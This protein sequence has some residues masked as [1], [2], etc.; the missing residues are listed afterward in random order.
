M[1][2]LLIT[3]F[4]AA[5]ALLAPIYIP[6]LLGSGWDNVVPVVSILC[7]SAL[8]ITLW[9]VSATRLRL[10]GHPE[11]ELGVDALLVLMLALSAVVTAPIGLVAMAC[12]YL[13]TTSAVLLAASLPMFVPP[14]NH[15]IREV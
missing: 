12:G 1:S 10:K 2:L 13:A 8:P 3:P 15:P 9:T 5:Q 6:L 4:I 11:I 7:L 14:L